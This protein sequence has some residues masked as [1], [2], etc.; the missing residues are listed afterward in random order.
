MIL[1]PIG[2]MQESATLSTVAVVSEQSLK[3]KSHSFFIETLQFLSEMNADFYEAKRDFYISLSESADIS[4]VHE[5]FGDFFG[6]VKEIIDK[7]LA[8]LKSLLDRFVTLMNQLI[9]RDKHI[10]NHKKELDNFSKIHE[11]SITGFKYSIEDD[12]PVI[13]A[14]A[15]FDSDFIFEF[16]GDSVV[17]SGP[18][19]NIPKKLVAHT[20]QMSDQ[21]ISG[22]W[23]DKFRGTVLGEENKPI[24]KDD[25]ADRLF[26]EF[27]SNDPIAEEITIDHS[28]VKAA[29]RRFETA[30]S[31][32]EKAKKTKARIE[33]DYNAIKH[34]VEKM[35]VT[36]RNGSS[37]ITKFDRELNVDYQTANKDDIVA[38]DNFVKA[39]VNQIQEMSNIHALAF[40]AK[41]DAMRDS[42]K[43]DKAVLF[44]ALSRVQSNEKED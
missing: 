19:D 21:L 31:D 39:K 27:R 22:E 23:Y 1:N 8:F 40:A 24:T 34:K 36:N 20:K 16:N 13:T 30:K 35:V 41:L 4:V 18:K 17:F 15:A 5:S 26:A 6:K 2:L 33:S 12:I 9:G 28:E 14:K 10:I 29:L 38:M 7:F 43:Q 25:F 3:E 42:Y 44:K 32:I 11:F 37:T